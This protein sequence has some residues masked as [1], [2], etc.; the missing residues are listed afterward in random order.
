MKMR[1]IC[2]ALLLVSLISCTK[3]IAVEEEEG[4]PKSFHLQ[5]VGASARDL[6]SDE[7]FTSLRIEV[8]Y[9]TGYEPDER[10]LL[11]LRYFLY[12]RLHKPGG[13]SIITQEIAPEADSSLSFEEIIAIEKANRKEYAAG[14]ELTL[15][16][17]YTNGYYKEDMMLGYAYLNTSAVLFGRNLDDNSNKFKKL[18]RSDLET[19]VLQH[20]VA[21]LLGLV[22]VGTALQSAHKDDDHGKHCSNKQCLMY[23]LTDTEESPS[24]LLRKGIPKL[25][26]ACLADLR[27]NGGR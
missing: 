6:L 25:D 2:F 9:M 8:Q 4:L 12:E 17:L 27:A 3:S 1:L 11:N 19:R 7:R 5:K 14:K 13:I 20:E 10:A 23:Y 24:I 15:Y 21:H 22:N 18:N 26:D 16:I